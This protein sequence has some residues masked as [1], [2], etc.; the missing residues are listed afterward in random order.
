L[1]LVHLAPAAARVGIQVTAETSEISPSQIV[2]V[3]Q[4]V[5]V[6]LQRMA[7]VPVAALG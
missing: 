1:V 4:V 3:P 6:T 2:A 7:G 5:V